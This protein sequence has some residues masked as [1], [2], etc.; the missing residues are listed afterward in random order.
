MDYLEIFKND[1]IGKTLQLSIDK[2]NIFIRVDR[3]N[4]DDCG[5]VAVTGPTLHHIVDDN[6]KTTAYSLNVGETFSICHLMDSNTLPYYYEF[7][8]D[9]MFTYCVNKFEQIVQN[10]LLEFLVN[11]M[12]NGCQEEVDTNVEE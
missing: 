8:D 5:N 9:M 6:Y 1:T 2:E 7:N 3:I 12:E 4:I 10:I 11:S